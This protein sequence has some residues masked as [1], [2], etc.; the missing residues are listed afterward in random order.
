M[1]VGVELMEVEQIFTRA[2]LPPFEETEFIKNLPNNY[3]GGRSAK[4]KLFSEN[5]S[6]FR[7]EVSSVLRQQAL[8]LCAR[9]SK[10]F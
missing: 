1:Q 3:L 6:D 10:A 8:L 4:K 9:M 7:H 5:A 2:T